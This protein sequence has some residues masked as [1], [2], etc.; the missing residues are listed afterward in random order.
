MEFL[1][2]PRSLLGTGFLLVCLVGTLG[3]AILLRA[4]VEFGELC[5]RLLGEGLMPHG[6]CYMWDPGL[7]WMHV[8]ADSVIGLS[9]FSIPVGL[10]IFAKKRPEAT[11]RGLL[12]L[13]GAFICLCGITHSLAVYIVW[14]GAYWISG[15]AKV[16]T[17][18]VS[19]ITAVVLLRL[20]PQALSIPLPQEFQ[21][22][23]EQLKTESLVRERVQRRLDART[24]K[25]TKE[26]W[27]SDSRWRMLSEFIYSA[28]WITDSEGRATQPMPSWGAFT[29][30]DRATYRDYGWLRA[31]HPE[32]RERMKLEWEKSVEAGNT[33]QLEA[34][35][36]SAAASDYIPVVTK[37]IPWRD[38]KG[39]VI[40]WLGAVYDLSE[41]KYQALQ[42]ERYS[43]RLQAQN[44]QLQEFAYA[45]SH[46]LREPL[47]KIVA[48]G[49]VLEEDYGQLLP[50]DGKD[51]IQVMQSAAQ[52]MGGLINDLLAYSRISNAD[53]DI[54]EI[55]LERVLKQVLEDLEVAVKESEA[56]FELSGM[57]CVIADRVQ[58]RSLMQNLLGNALKYRSKDRPAKVS[59]S[60]RRIEA[61]ELPNPEPAG[62]DNRYFEIQV[63]DNGIGFEESKAELIFKPFGRLHNRSEYSG[64]G[65]GL[66][67]CRRIVDRHQGQIS[68]NSEV[69]LGSRFHIFLP[70]NPRANNE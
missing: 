55:D 29:G 54:Q 64:V 33:Y 67:M 27:D 20:L 58:L 13:F 17:A 8:G 4:P 34:R 30:Q 11:F 26:L 42:L 10:A 36:W 38:D 61:D 41:A 65:M 1:K 14:E 62:P 19:L 9:Y 60:L 45:A 16:A 68:V 3:I 21:K 59:V 28:I 6:V 5:S 39:E 53:I 46:D 52:R 48:Y 66:A 49:G 24:S 2:S 40:E 32:D 51:C 7:L 69:G 63:A 44:E 23:S 35:L 12:L 47:R 15:I 57:G 25:Q 37:G 70:E 43:R 31:Y 22:V 56:T 50:D 18:V